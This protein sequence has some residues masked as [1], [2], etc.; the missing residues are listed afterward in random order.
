MKIALVYRKGNPRLK[1]GLVLAGHEAKENIPEINT[2]LSEGINAVVFEFKYIIKE[3]WKLLSLAYK[4]RQ[5]GIPIVHGMS[6]PHGT[7][8]LK[9]G[10]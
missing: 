2:F 9:N 7:Q 5:H 1:E 8:E 3:G 10:K 6:I 4:L